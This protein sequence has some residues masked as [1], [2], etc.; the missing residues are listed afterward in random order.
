V[1]TRR[2][3]QRVSRTQPGPYGWVGSCSSRWEWT[4]PISPGRKPVA[5]MTVSGSART[6]PSSW[7]IIPWSTVASWHWRLALSGVRTRFKRLLPILRP[8]DVAQR[9]ATAVEKDRR[10]LIMPAMVR[11]VPTLRALP[12]PVFDKVMDLSESTCPWTNS[13]ATTVTARALR[14]GVGPSAGR[15]TGARCSVPTWSVAATWS[16]VDP[17]N[18]DAEVPG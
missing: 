14:S 4:S 11:L 9:I 1:L 2:P 6:S 13:S 15:T 8:E 5:G 18:G 7:S 3:G 10:R 17:L 16:R 12:P